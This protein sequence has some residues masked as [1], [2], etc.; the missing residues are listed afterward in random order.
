M[1]RRRRFAVA[2]AALALTACSVDR[3]D[4]A[5]SEP[6]QTPSPE[7]SSDAST[8]PPV[9]HSPRNTPQQR[10]VAPDD[11][12]APIAM[13]A[14]RHL[15]GT[16]GP[17]EATSRSFRRAATWV[18]SAFERLGYDVS[19]QRVDVPAGTSWLGDPVPAG[20]SVNVIATP[21]G[22]DPTEPHLV[23]G[24][25]LDTVAEAPGAE[26]NAS[27]VG[28]VL[29]AASA[30]A[31]RRTRLPVVFVAFGA[32]EPRGPGD[33]DHHFG[34]RAYVASL[35]PEERRAVRGMVSLDRV[36]VGTRVPVG[37]ASGSDPV[38]RSLLAAG[39]RAGVATVADPDQR[40][41]DHWSFVRAGLPGAR[42]GSTSYAAYHD[43]S[44]L[45]PVV[46]P[47]QLERT[48]RLLLAWLGPR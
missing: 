16:I 4:Q 18:G 48:G 47:A 20:R 40:S 26:D 13:G 19:R 14:V 30:V 31:E 9:E 2:A 8:E 27:G 11:L 5:L 29:A 15:A 42:L 38:Q 34:S 41:S 6:Q 12:D 35:G 43:A 17:R 44:D 25:H 22:F 23:V 36:G 37:S 28:V 7:S 32:E 21:A 45:P 39:R 10:S 33:D 24:A 3:A 1:A 46:S